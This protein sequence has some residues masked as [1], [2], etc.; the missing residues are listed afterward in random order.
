LWW[1]PI[2]EVFELSGEDAESGK[3][4]IDTALLKLNGV[5]ISDPNSIIKTVR[6]VYAEAKRTGR[7]EQSF[8]EWS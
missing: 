6:S 1:G 3:R 8:V 4:L 7:T 2:D 5:T